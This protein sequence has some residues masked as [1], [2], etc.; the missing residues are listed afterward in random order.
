MQ[1]LKEDFLILDLLFES[2][3][4]DYTELKK[5]NIDKFFFNEYSNQRVV[6]SFLFNYI[7]IQ[8]KIGAKVF[9]NLLYE[10]KEISDYSIPM[11]DVL[12]IFEKMNI[13]ESADDWDRLREI[14]NSITHDY[15]ADIE[16]RIENIIL[17]LEGYEL[18]KKIFIR[19]KDYSQRRGLLD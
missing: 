11:I 18:L 15:P 12:N 5:G 14:R 19:I 7:K 16:E 17:A 2:C 4:I 13:I 10:L 3:E 6:N 9:K 8:D 1:I